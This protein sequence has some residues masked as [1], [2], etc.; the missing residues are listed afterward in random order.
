VLQSF[1]KEHGMTGP[2]QELPP[3]VQAR[4]GTNSFGRTVRYYFNYSG[5]PVSFNYRHKP[6]TDLLANRH[7]RAD[8]SLTLGPWDLAIIEEDA[9]AKGAK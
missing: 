7:A 4:T 6:G 2:D 9:A 8:D 3:N 1:L 5:A